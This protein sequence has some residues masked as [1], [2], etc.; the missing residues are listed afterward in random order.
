MS[1]V[2]SIWCRSQKDSIIGIGKNIPW[3][4]PE[5]KKNFRDIVKNKTMVMGRKTYESIEPCLLETNKIYVMSQNSEYE[6]I[7]FLM[8]S[9]V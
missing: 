4:E 6:V 9:V 5:D 7:N 3:D 8:A 2:V 1:N